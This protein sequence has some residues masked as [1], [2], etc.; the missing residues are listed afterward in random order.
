MNPITAAV[1]PASTPWQDAGRPRSLADRVLAQGGDA[2]VSGDADDTGA[3]DGELTP[4]PQPVPDMETA[5]SEW[6]RQMFTETMM[7]EDEEATG[8]PVLSI[9]I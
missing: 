2:A 8:I 5:I 4:L 9:E 6:A 1:S 3:G 7:T